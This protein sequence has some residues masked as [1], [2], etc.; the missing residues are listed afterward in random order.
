MNQYG[1]KR[2]CQHLLP[3]PPPPDRS[4]SARCKEDA[5]IYLFFSAPTLFWG[6]RKLRLVAM[7][8]FIQG[9]KISDL[10]PRLIR[11]SR[12]TFAAAVQ[13]IGLDPSFMSSSMIKPTAKQMA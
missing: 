5:L 9:G 4:H 3:A 8:W 2:T 11:H 10:Q 12:R 6:G 13:D 7:C 1:H